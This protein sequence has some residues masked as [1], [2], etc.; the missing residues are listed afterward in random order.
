MIAAAVWARSLH[1][2]APWQ[3]GKHSRPDPSSPP[4]AEPSGSTGRGRGLCENTPSH[5]SQLQVQDPS[6]VPIGRSR[7]L[8]REEAPGAATSATRLPFAVSSP[9]L[10]SR[11]EAPGATTSWTRLLF[12]VSAVWTNDEAKRSG[13]EQ[14]WRY[15][16]ADCCRDCI[17]K[18]SGTTPCRRHGL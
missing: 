17:G 10:L 13:P 14:S 8:S 9:R 12:A 15:S 4:F 3:H 6:S 2:A 11:E 18:R 16:A 7:L 1:R 5:S